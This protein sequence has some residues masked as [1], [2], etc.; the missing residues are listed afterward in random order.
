MN[1]NAHHRRRRNQP[2]RGPLPSN[3]NRDT[4][5]PGTG[6]VSKVSTRNRN[7]TVKHEPAQHMQSPNAPSPERSQ[8]PR[9]AASDPRQLWLPLA[10]HT[11]CDLRKCLKTTVE[12]GGVEPAWATLR[13]RRS[14]HVSPGVSR[15]LHRNRTVDGEYRPHAARAMM[16]ARRPVP[17][18]GLLERDGELRALVQHYLD[19]R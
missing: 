2:K 9:R 1:A 8:S 17:K 12:V 15:E 5:K 10:G 18:Q 11:H 16:R 14:G 7:H 19:Q 6:P 4:C 3:R 13:H